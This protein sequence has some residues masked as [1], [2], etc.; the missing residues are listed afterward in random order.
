MLG[1]STSWPLQLPA[2]LTSRLLELPEEQWRD[3][4][5]WSGAPHAPRHHGPGPDVAMGVVTACFGSTPARRPARRPDRAARWTTCSPVWRT[6]RSTANPSTACRSSTKPACSSRAAGTSRGDRPRPAG[7]LRPPGPV[8]TARRAPRAIPTA[9]EELLRWV[10][11]EQLLPHRRVDTGSAARRSPPATG[12]PAVPSASR[13]GPCS[14][15]LRFDV[16]RSPDHHVAFGYG[17]HFCPRRQPPARP[18]GSCSRLSARLT[19]LRGEQ[20]RRGAQPLRPGGADLRARLPPA[21]ND[22]ARGAGAPPLSGAGRARGRA[23]PAVPVRVTASLPRAPRAD[24]GPARGVSHIAGG[25]AAGPRRG[26]WPRGG[27][28]GRRAR[29]H[30]RGAPR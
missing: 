20:A 1:S 18:C 15:A 29:V 2:R 19:D 9:V 13:D 17:T 24:V 25:I 10:A 27:S 26:P 12:D 8:G 28:P 7:V 11:P 16:T 5:G 22:P 14:T 23:G 21:L 3:L 6:P 4:K 30:G